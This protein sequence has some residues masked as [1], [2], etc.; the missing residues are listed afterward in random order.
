MW[1][2]G[3]ILYELLTLHR[4]FKGPSQREIMQQVLYGKYDPFP[5]NVS[6]GMKTMLDA[7]L[8]KNPA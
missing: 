6:S 7:L 8:S 2:L 1:S 5:C 3:V 4:P